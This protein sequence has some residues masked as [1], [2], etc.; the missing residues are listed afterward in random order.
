VPSH[1]TPLEALAPT[2]SESVS[3]RTEPL[4]PAEAEA[5]TRDLVG[6]TRSLF[7]LVLPTGP[8]GT[9]TEPTPPPPAPRPAAPASIPM[10]ASVPASVPASIP[11]PP[12]ADPEPAAPLRGP[13]PIQLPTEPVRP[14]RAH[15]ERTM[16]LLDEIAFLDD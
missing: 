11:M 8:A 15:Q 2:G 5:L 13:E 12:L 4:T 6:L 9:V 14:E 16:S 7:A 3:D 10:P 1:T